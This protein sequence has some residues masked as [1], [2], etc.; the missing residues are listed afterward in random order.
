MATV[1]IDLDCFDDL[2]PFATELTDPVAILIQDVYHILIERPGSNIDDVDRGI[3]IDEMLSGVV[4]PT[5]ATRI[6]A[7]L[8]KDDRIDVSQTTIEDLGGESYRVSLR[9]QYDEEALNL[10]FVKDD[11]GFRRVT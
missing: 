1:D 3:G 10:V 8:Q 7:Q 2:N 5:L 9:I 11:E 6:D 4:D